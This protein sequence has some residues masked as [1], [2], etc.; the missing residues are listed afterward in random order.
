MRKPIGL[1][2]FPWLVEKLCALGEVFPNA[3]DQLEVRGWYDIGLTHQ[4]FL[5]SVDCPKTKKER[6]EE[7]RKKK[8]YNE[9]R[10]GKRSVEPAHKKRSHLRLC[11]IDTN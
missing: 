2:F 10:E 6:E 1:L 5:G 9:K 7:E 3:N 8:T 4:M 11:A